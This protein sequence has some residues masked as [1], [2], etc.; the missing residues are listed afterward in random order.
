MK[1]SDSRA[2]KGKVSRGGGLPQNSF[3]DTDQIEV[4]SLS[5]NSRTCCHHPFLRKASRIP[6][7]RAIEHHKHIPLSHF[8]SL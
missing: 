7:V 6:E 3:Q 8:A 2:G 5:K 4:E 1:Q